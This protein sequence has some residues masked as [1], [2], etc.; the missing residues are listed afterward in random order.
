V[1][2]H[3]G[4][5]GLGLRISHVLSIPRGPV[6]PQASGTIR[7]RCIESMGIYASERNPGREINIRRLKVET[8]VTVLQPL[9]SVFVGKQSR[10]AS[11]GSVGGAVQGGIIQDHLGGK[12]QGGLDSVQAFASNFLLQ[13]EGLLPVK[14]G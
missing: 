4:G 6:L 11:R 1:C 13:K 10:I 5:P 8:R 7:M 14:C 9:W 2:K 12:A 3:M